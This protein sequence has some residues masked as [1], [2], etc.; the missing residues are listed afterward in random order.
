MYFLHSDD[1][2]QRPLSVGGIVTVWSPVLQVCIQQLH[3][4]KITTYSLFWWNPILLNWR[5]AIEW[6]F[7]YSECS[8][9]VETR[10]WWWWYCTSEI[11]SDVETSKFFSWPTDDTEERYLFAIKY[12]FFLEPAKR[13]YMPNLH[14]SPFGQRAIDIHSDR[15]SIPHPPISD[16]FF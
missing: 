11:V 5:Q 13:R 8:A 6:S 10:D 2:C 3:Y 4:I 1:I 14:D 16:V 12:F 9:Y 7:P 15:P